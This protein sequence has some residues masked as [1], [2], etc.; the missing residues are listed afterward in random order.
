MFGTTVLSSSS[1]EEAL[2]R[3][4][5]EVR[6]PPGNGPVPLWRA[7]VFISFDLGFF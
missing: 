2:G 7:S 6:S 5:P 3:N 1:K 4:R